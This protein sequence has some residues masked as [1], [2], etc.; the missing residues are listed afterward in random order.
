MPSV[1]AGSSHILTGP[2][3]RLS[4][5]ARSQVEVRSTRSPGASEPDPSPDGRMI[6]NPA[7]PDV[8]LAVGRPTQESPGYVEF[9]SPS[10]VRFINRLRTSP[11]DS[12]GVPF[13]GA[14]RSRVLRLSWF[15]STSSNQ[16]R[17]VRM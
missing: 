13:R 2:A 6:Y 5:R 15:D 14:S 10:W 8:E 16:L 9:S 12:R 7:Y 1:T 3:T 17:M 4:I 11:F